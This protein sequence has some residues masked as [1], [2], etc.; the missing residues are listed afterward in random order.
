METKLA[1]TVL[2]YVHKVNCLK[3]TTV[4]LVFS[5]LLA[6]LF[7]IFVYCMLVKHVLNKKSRF[8]KKPLFTANEKDFY[9]WLVRALPEYSVHAQVAMGALIKVSPGKNAIGERAKFSQKII[10][11]VVC[12]SEDN[13]VVLIELDD[14]THNRVKDKLRD[15]MTAAAGYVTLRYESKSK[16]SVSKFLSDFKKAIN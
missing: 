1:F 9:R 10:D 12:D 16:P 8:M 3:S 15:A 7:L 13:V 4:G 11:F 14:V 2:A 5:S 6:T